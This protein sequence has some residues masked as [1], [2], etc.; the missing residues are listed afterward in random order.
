[1]IRMVVASTQYAEQHHLYSSAVFDHV[2]HSRRDCG[3]S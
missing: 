1:M 3:L 2:D